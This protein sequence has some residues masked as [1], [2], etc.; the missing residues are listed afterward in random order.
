MTYALIIDSKHERASGDFL[1]FGFWLAG[2]VEMLG[3]H[4]WATVSKEPWGGP[5]GVTPTLLC[6]LL[7]SARQEL[8]QE[9]TAN[10]MPRA[11]WLP[12]RIASA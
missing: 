6:L 3:C 1:Y 8:T 11:F 5:D 4:G 10:A 7:V 9:K 12:P 2:Q